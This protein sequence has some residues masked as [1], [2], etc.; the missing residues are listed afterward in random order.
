MLR[1]WQKRGLMGGSRLDD[2]A[3]TAMF[4]RK[5]LGLIHELF[6]MRTTAD[7]NIHRQPEPFRSCCY[8]ML[9]KG[10]QRTEDG[11]HQLQSMRH[12]RRALA[13]LL[14]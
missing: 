13:R 4:S 7:Y 14:I 2:D 10:C 12:F 8:L 11:V 3:L 5:M 1:I 9:R 6:A